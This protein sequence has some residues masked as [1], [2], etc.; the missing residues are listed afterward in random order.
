[1]NTLAVLPGRKWQEQ[2]GYYLN[3]IYLSGIS[4]HLVEKKHQK[5]SLF[6]TLKC[7]DLETT[8]MEPQVNPTLE[9]KINII[10]YQDKTNRNQL[11][12][13]KTH[14]NT[15]STNGTNTSD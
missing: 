3:N 8:V 12:K 10:I 5:M 2:H 4:D 11:Y 7:V 1:M 6:M 9:S 13:T 14:Q 15:N